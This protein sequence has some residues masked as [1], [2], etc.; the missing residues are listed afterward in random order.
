M[1]SLAVLVV[2]LIFTCAFSGPIALL[3]SSK[4]I[5]ALTERTTLTIIRRAIMAIINFFGIVVCAFFLLAQIPFLFKAVALA[6]LCLNL[7]AI[8]R[9]YG[10]KV[11]TYVKK[12]LQRD[13]NG[14]VGQI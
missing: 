1:Y 6:S 11:A 8:D 9:E 10:A 5:R 2:I 12:R 4:K 3:L 13:P 14:P 7:F